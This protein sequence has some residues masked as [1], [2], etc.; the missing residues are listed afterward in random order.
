MPYIGK[1]PNFG[2]RTRYYYTASGSETTLSG[3]DD[4]GL[5]LKFTDGQYVDVKLNGVSLVAGTDYNTNTANTIS[6]LAALTAGQIAEIVVFDAFS[7]ANTV[8]V[9]GGTYSGAVVYDSD[10]TYNKALQGNTSTDTTNTGNITLDFDTFQN[11]VLTFTGNVTFDNPSTE[12]VGQSGFIVIIQD[13]T[14]GRTLSLGTDFETAGGGSV[15]L[16]STASATDMIPYIVVASNRIL[17]GT[18]LL[19]FS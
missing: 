15:T 12:A 18:P 1:A 8:P 3:A 19:A 2:I 17:L 16:T 7:V 9:T 14:G 4:N 6:G 10:V 13:S 5:T 11:F